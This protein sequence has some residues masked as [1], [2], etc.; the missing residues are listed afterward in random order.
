MINENVTAQELREEDAFLDQILDTSVM[1]LAMTYLQQKGFY[2]W[3]LNNLFLIALCFFFNIWTGIVRSDRASQKELLKTAWFTIYSRGG[4]RFGSCGFEHGNSLKFSWKCW[5]IK[6]K[7]RDA[8]FLVFMNE[9]KN[10]EITGLHNWI[11][12]HE[13]EQDSHHYLDYRGYMKS[14]HMGNVIIAI[15]FCFS[16]ILVLFWYSFWNLELKRF[17]L[18]IFRKRKSSNIAWRIKMWINQLIQ[19]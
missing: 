18:S 12:F 4:G 13:Q 14:L 10:N 9:I 8:C 19:C 1:K 15:L 3:D 6:M 11:Y 7:K 17:T 2:F 5:L 16:F